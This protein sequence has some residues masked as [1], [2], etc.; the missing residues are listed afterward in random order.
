MIPNV[1]LLPS[2]GEPFHNPG[3]YQRLA[4]KLDYLTITRP[5]INFAFSVVSQLMDVDNNA[6]GCIVK[7]VKGAP[8][9][10]LLHRNK[11]HTQ[12]VGYN[13]ADWA[14]CPFDW[15]PHYWVLHAHWRTSNLLEDQE[16]EC[17]SSP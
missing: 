12:I 4:G 6:L 3:T 13:N 10:G 14:G 2:E 16:T 8:G 9:S 17:C 11:C 1:K 7:Y 15:D 5:D